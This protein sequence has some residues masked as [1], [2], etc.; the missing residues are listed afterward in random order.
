MSRILVRKSSCTEASE[1]RTERKAGAIS[2]RGGDEARENSRRPA[3]R[4]QR[5]GA[6][7]GAGAQ[8]AG[9]RETFSPRPTF[10]R[11]A[12]VTSNSSIMM[13]PTG[14]PTC[15]MPYYPES[16]VDRDVHSETSGCKFYVVLH[17]FVKGTYT[18]ASRAN[19]QV[20]RYSNFAMCKT[21]TYE[22][23]EEEWAAN[24]CRLHGAVCPVAQMQQRA[25]PPPSAHSSSAEAPRAPWFTGAER[26]LFN[27]ASASAPLATAGPTVTLQHSTTPSFA[28]GLP[29]FSAMAPQPGFSFPAAK[30]SSS[31]SKEF[32]ASG[33]TSAASPSKSKSASAAS[34]T[35]ST[36]TPVASGASAF[37]QMGTGGPVHVHWGVKGLFRTFASRVE[38]LD[39]AKFLGIPTTHVAGD[40]DPAVMEAWVRA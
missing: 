36:T 2:G 37:T 38:A 32:P 19:D 27:S 29:Q 12:P 3:R 33:S 1:W 9:A 18:S 14:R 40:A 21:N 25:L 28:A 30:A 5:E 7:A 24:C 22:E 13:T 39:A 10:S 26:Q 8:M 6:G 17:G 15:T 4:W 16:G 35:P 23:A 20:I 34:F 11:S 31:A